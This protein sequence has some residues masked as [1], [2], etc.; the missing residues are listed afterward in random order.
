MTVTISSVKS[1]KA[2]VLSTL[3]FI[4]CFANWTIFSILGIKLK[5]E[6]GL[7]DTQFGILIATPILTGALSRLFLGIWTDQYGGR[8]VLPIVMLISAAAT[9]L[10]PHAT[11]YNML[12]VTALG[13]GFAGGAF[14]VGIAYVSKW[15]S[16]QRQG[17]ALGIFGCGN[18]GSAITASLVPLLLVPYGWKT[19]AE[20]YAFCMVLAAL[21]FYIFSD[22]DP[23][24]VRRRQAKIKPV[25][26]IDQLQPLKNLQV[27]RFSLYY[28]FTFGAFVALVLWLPRYCMGVYGVSVA[29]AGMIAA[30]AYNTPGSLFRI[31]GGWASDKYGA[32]KVMYITFIGSLICTFILSYPA[33][34]YSV[35]GINGDITFTMS[36][37]LKSFIAILFLL[38]FFM[39]L[40]KA[41]VFK[42]IP[43]YYPDNVGAVGGIVGLIGGLGGFILPITFGYMNDKIGVWTSCFML[44]T[45]ITFSSLTWMHFAIQ[46][47]DKKQYPELRGPKYLPELSNN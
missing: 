21:F 15:F 32:R 10:L 1:T 25:G 3:V 33:T 31:L 34:Q 8:I 47:L 20:V 4:I 40:G 27:W 11:T 18:V 28:F 14:A 19:V 43:I 22:D 30:M 7:T 42:H 24:L 36:L 6:F 12:L 16:K 41:A 26:I 39:S 35:H 37:G 2:L 38:G 23:D 29:T 5:A 13:I 9:Y 46:S 44:L 17:T 45:I